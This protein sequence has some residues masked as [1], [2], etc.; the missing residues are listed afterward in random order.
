VE[1][2]TAPTTLPAAT[3]T[4]T[5]NLCRYPLVSRYDGRNDPDA[6]SSYR[7]AHSY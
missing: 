5:R 4:T 7:C 1:H 2:G 3:A 6:A